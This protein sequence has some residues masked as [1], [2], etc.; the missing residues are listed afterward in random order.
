[1]SSLTKPRIRRTAQNTQFTYNLS[2]RVHDVQTYPTRSPQGA[3]ILICGHESGITL[4]WRGGR[5]L[6]APQKQAANDTQN[7]N[8]NDTV[9]IIDSDDE[10][11]PS[12]AHSTPNYEDNPQFEESVQETPYPETIQT[13]DLALGTAVLHVAVIPMAPGA[14][15]EAGTEGAGILAEKMVF[16]VSCVTN[17]V[18]VIILPLTPP[19]HESKARLELRS[20]L[21]A[22]KAGS[23]CWGE[24]LIS[25]RGQTK[26]SDGLAINLIKPKSPDTQHR[27]P[28]IVVAAHSRQASGVML[29]WDVPLEL[30]SKPDHALEPFQ[31][32]FLPNPLTRISFNPTHDTQLLV[33]C[34]R[35]AARIYDFAASSLPPDPETVGPFPAQGSWL[36]SL[37]QPFTRPTCARK[38][39][40]DAAWISHGRAVFCLLAD[41]MWGI[42]DVDGASPISP[43]S[44]MTKRLKVGVQGAALTAFSVFGYVE[45]AGSLRNA[46]TLSRDNLGGELAPMTPH[47]RRQAT[48]AL[49]SSA[50]LDRLSTVHG[51]V[52]SMA[53][54]MNGRGLQDESLVLW[55]GGAE[56][57][58]VIPAVSRF[59]EWQLRKGAGGGVN[60]FSGAQPTRMIKLLDLSTGL[61]GESCAGVG[62][63]ADQFIT[64]EPVNQDSG[65]PVDVVLQGESRVV[66]VRQG[67]DGPGKKIGGVVGGR[68]RRLFSRGERSDA[69]IVRG[70]HDRTASLSFNLSFSQPGTLRTPGFKK[71]DK[72]GDDFGAGRP[73]SRPKVGLDFM[74]SL[75]E[76]ADISDDLTRD[77]EC[78][79]LD[80]MEIED[81]L[82]DMEDNRGSGRKKVFFDK[83]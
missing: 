3:T 18:Y 63:V 56:H 47:T 76:A 35:Y 27:T 25:L 36:L 11:P 9:M 23:G 16:A 30:K 77:V 68:G 14:A 4:L 48:T 79:M 33:V 39:I 58:C 57:V 64:G 50:A 6:K 52:R 20:E 74:K 65:I 75:N 8:P 67:E 22:G 13:L 41:G 10:Q 66:I 24:A 51:G 72:Q 45:G 21:L 61:L 32:E 73:P 54:P 29:L 46:G 26:H 42:W 1:M 59:W 53:V 43:S 28:R 70:S 81:S 55:I 60:L 12:K 62:L 71:Q 69:I 44:A 78:E 82:N 19:S 31:T 80:I 2:Q 40:V 49:S 17:D 34:S 15:Q 7:G 38:P 83:D 37:Y 5:R